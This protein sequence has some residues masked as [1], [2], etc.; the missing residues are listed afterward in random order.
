[1]VWQGVGHLTYCGSKGGYRT[2]GVFTINLP[3]A[4]GK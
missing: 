1:M 2:G 3:E 4:E